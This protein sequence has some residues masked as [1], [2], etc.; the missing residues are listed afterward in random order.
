[1]VELIRGKVYKMSPAPSRFHQDISVNLTRLLGNF[2][3]KSPCK[4]YHAPTDVRLIGKGKEDQEIVSV[5]QPDIF[6]VCDP[7][8][9]DEKGCLG[10]PD[11]IIEFVSP[12]TSSKD[13]DLKFNLYESAGVKEYWIIFPNDKIV[14]CFVLNNGTFKKSG[15]YAESALIPIHALPGLELKLE[16]IFER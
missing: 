12:G 5:V 11:F 7:D 16:E 10:S 1:M 13:L 3:Y 14:E 15:V 9:M 6:V 8:K 4:I 2:L